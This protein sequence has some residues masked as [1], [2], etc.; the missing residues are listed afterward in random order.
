MSIFTDPK[1]ITIEH[2][3]DDEPE[4]PRTPWGRAQGTYTLGDG[5]MIASCAGHGGIRVAG[6][7]Y[8]AIPKTLRKRWYEEDCASYIPI[9]FNYEALK[10]LAMAAN[11]KERRRTGIL[12]Y[13]MN[14]DKSDVFKSLRRWFGAEM[15]VLVFKNKS[16]LPQETA[17]LEDDEDYLYYLRQFNKIVE[18]EKLQERKASITAGLSDGDIVEFNHEIYFSFGAD[19]PS[20]TKFKVVKQG[21]AIRFIP[22]SDHY[23]FIAQIRNWRSLVKAVYRPTQ[24]AA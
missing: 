13:V 6:A 17:G 22:V 4:A 8:N 1:D 15:D 12:N 5:F 11:E 10:A 3:Y 2:F 23:N 20:F 19:K 18:H 24:N 9:F 14:T 21:R 7:A 16:P